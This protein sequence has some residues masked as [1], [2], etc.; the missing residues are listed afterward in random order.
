M[1]GRVAPSQPTKARPGTLMDTDQRPPVGGQTAAA[2][3][4]RHAA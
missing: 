3:L 4:R 1:S 2:G